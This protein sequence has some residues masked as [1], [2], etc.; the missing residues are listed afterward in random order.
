MKKLTL[1]IEQMK[2][3]QEIGFNLD[4]TTPLTLPDIL[5]MLPRIL[6]D[7]TLTLQKRVGHWACFYMENYT[8]S[9]IQFYAEIECI[10][11]AYN[12]LCWLYEINY[13]P[14]LN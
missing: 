12:M 1:S 7:H 10:D 9:I 3:L 14:F 5:D 6:D 8:K 2:H 4:T 13:L 11:A